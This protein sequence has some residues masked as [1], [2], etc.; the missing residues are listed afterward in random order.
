VASP[1][2]IGGRYCENCP[3]GHIVADKLAISAISEGVRAYA[4]DPNNAEALW[5]KSEQMVGEK[6]I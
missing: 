6:F 4:L 5:N 3:V 1:E 2:E